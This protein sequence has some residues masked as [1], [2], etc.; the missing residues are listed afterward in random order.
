MRVPSEPRNVWNV[1]DKVGCRSSRWS[2]R[3]YGLTMSAPA[4]L[5]ESLWTQATRADVLLSLGSAL[6]SSGFLSY[7]AQRW[8]ELTGGRWPASIFIGIGATCVLALVISICLVAYRYYK[9]LPAQKQRSAEAEGK[10]DV[11]Q[12]T[13]WISDLRLVRSDP[14]KQVS[15]VVTPARGGTTLGVFVDLSHWSTAI[16]SARWTGPERLY[17]GP[18]QLIAPN[19]KFSHTVLEKGPPD[20]SATNLRGWLWKSLKADGMPSG[21]QPCF[22]HGKLRAVFVFIDPQ[23]NEEAFPFLLL[24]EIN[25]PDVAPTVVT[26]EDFPTI[27]VN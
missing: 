22:V 13:R 4:T 12:G 17:L 25:N 5:K 2:A 15:L 10:K 1:A 11:P 3:W 9:P 7:V 24:K 27:S 14:A 8:T 26:L 6:V 19:L 16:G 23:G 18:V 20:L 21:T